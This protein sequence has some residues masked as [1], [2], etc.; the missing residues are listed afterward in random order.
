MTFPSGH[1]VNYSVD[2]AG[3]H[4]KVHTNTK[5]YADLTVATA[6]YKSYTPDGRIEQMRLGNELWETRDYQTPGAP[7]LFKLGSTAGAGN[8]LQLEYNYHG[9]ENNGN[10]VSHGI[11]QPG[12]TWRQSY[13][14][15]GVNRLKC[16]AEALN[17]A[18]EN[19]CTQGAWRQTFGYDAYGNRWVASATG[20]TGV[21]FHEPTAQSNFDA[22]TNRLY[23]NNSAYDAAGNQTRYEPW[24][25][26]YDAENRIKSAVTTPNASDGTGTYVYDADGRRIKK[27]WTAGT[28]THTTYYLYN[29]LGQLVA[30]YSTQAAVSTGTAYIHTDMLGSVRMV[31]GEKPSNAPAPILECYDY[32]PFGRLLNSADNSRNTGCY[33]NSPDTQITSRLPQKFTGKERDAET[34]LDYFGARYFSAAQ[35]RFTSPD[36]PFAD[37]HPENPQSWNLYSYTRN[38]PLKYIDRQGEAIETAW[39]ALN[40]GWGIKSFVDNVRAGSYVSAA[41]DAVGV[42]VDTAADV[43]PFVPGGAGSIIKAGRIAGKADDLVEAVKALERSDDVVDVAKAAQAGRTGKQARL[44]EIANDPSAASADRGWIRQDMNQIDR[45]KRQSIRVPP[46]KE[47]AHERGREAAKGYNYKHSHLQN[48]IEHRTQHKYDNYGRKNKERKPEEEEEW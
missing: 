33:P 3:R 25:L 43:V 4:V 8:V 35:G 15:D 42:V 32:V 16:A 28:T 24:N 44:R 47:L 21:D 26:S 7:T 30:E 29:A 46:G 2:D 45:G 48:K 40:I 6:P 31:T 1:V 5:T 10:L 11:L 22:A 41:V 13:E 19:P 18:P 17:T 20:L 39:D 36:A 27:I 38:N 34:R 14:Y 23:V 12:R 37:Q 9:T